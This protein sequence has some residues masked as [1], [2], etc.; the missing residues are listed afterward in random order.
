MNHFKQRI[1]FSLNVIFVY[2]NIYKLNKFKPISA[3]LQLNK[4]SSMLEVTL[5]LNELKQ[6]AFDV[7]FTTKLS[8]GQHFIDHSFILFRHFMEYALLAIRD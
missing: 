8:V 4:L 7:V 2:R 1:I 3:R 5:A 6:I